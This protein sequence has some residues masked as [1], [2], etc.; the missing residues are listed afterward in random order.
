M[1][2]VFVVRVIVLLM[3]RGALAD[4]GDFVGVKAHAYSAASGGETGDLGG[5]LC[6]LNALRIFL[7]DTGEAFDTKLMDG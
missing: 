7:L 2:H 1:K 3:Q 5:L 4:R 6:P